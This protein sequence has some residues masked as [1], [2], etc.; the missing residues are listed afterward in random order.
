[1]SQTSSKEQHCILEGKVH[2]Y[3]FTDTN[4]DCWG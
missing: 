4:A 3:L 1:M 2:W